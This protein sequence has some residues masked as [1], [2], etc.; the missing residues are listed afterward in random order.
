MVVVD[1]TCI[2]NSPLIMNVGFLPLWYAA[3]RQIAI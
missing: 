2:T 3:A 1:T